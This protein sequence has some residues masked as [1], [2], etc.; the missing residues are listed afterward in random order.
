VADVER[1]V[2]ESLQRRA[3]QAP[4]GDWLLAAVHARSGRLRLR[5]RM[6]TSATAAVTV[7]LLAV[8]VPAGARLITGDPPTADPGQS[9]A[10]TSARTGIESAPPA[11]ADPS[12]P[13]AG[14]APLRLT[15]YPTP[16][17]PWR[18]DPS[19][20]LPKGGLKNPV[21]TLKD[22]AL[23]GFFEARDGYNGADV[24]IVVT[25]QRPTFA[26]SAAGPVK[27]VDTA[28][29]GHPGRLRTVAVSPAN[30][31]TLYWPESAG[32]WLQVRTDDTL[33]DAEVVQLANALL[34]AALPVD[35][36]LQLDLAPAG[37]TL[38]TVSRSTVVF[39]PAGPATD[40][41]S[42]TLVNTRPLNGV[43]TSVGPYPGA[44]TRTA[45]GAWLAV[46][47]DDRGLTLVV[48]V[49]AQYAISD[50]DLVRLAAGVHLTDRAESAGR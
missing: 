28:V 25:A 21:I 32:Q 3:E 33:T 47:L 34:P 29:R 27:E 8:A 11:S 14:T 9:Q 43:P 7:G 22:G 35:A 19:T 36:G 31:L 50:A 49:P 24:T 48:Q 42:L 4:T 20:G 26:G 45:A 46:N 6:W 18:P 16:S 41:I 38:D 5:R 2:R 30:Q 37:M 15:A 40:P 39:R 12:R 44:L 10:S 23:Q 17:L 1:L 13:A